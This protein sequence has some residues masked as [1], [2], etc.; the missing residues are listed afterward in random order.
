MKNQSMEMLDL[1]Y[2]VILLAI[3]ISTSMKA[4]YKTRH[5]IIHNSYSYMEDKNVGKAKGILINEYGAYDG[6]LSKLEVILMS[7]IQDDNMPY[8]R[9]L[10]VSGMNVDIPITYKEYAYQSGQNI[11]LMV[12]NDAND[13]RYSLNYTFITGDDGAITDEYFAIDK[14]IAEG[15][16][17]D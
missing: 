6:T 4:L 8:P 14:V 16:D 12:K 9:K 10:I 2:A 7:Q 15:K 11:W 5:E 3:I 13:T 17:N 1:A